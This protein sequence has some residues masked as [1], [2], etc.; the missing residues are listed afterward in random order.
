[1][2][3]QI[4]KSEPVTISFVGTLSIRDGIEAWAQAEDLSVS[5]LLRR[6]LKRALDIRRAAQQVAQA[7]RRG[8]L[9]AELFPGADADL[10]EDS[11]YPEGA[12]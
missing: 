11:L 2:E 4:T 9:P 6:E 3:P 8:P 7:A 5:Q 1:M 12:E 10:P